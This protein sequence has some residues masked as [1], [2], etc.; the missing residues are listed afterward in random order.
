D[1]RDDADAPPRGLADGVEVRFSH[2]PL[3]ARVGVGGGVKALEIA[4]ADGAEWIAAERA[5]CD[6][7]LVSGGWSPTIHL[8]SHRGTRPVWNDQ[9]ACFLA[10]P[11]DDDTSLATVGAAAGIWRTD[12][13]IAS[14]AFAGAAAARALGKHVVADIDTDIDTAAR[15]PKPGGWRWPIRPLYE[16]RA[17]G[18]K[19]KSLVDPLNDVTAD[20]IRLAHREGFVAVEHLKRYTTLGMSTDGGKVGNVIGLALMAEALGT[21][22]RQVG[23]T[24][25]RPPYTPVAL[26]ALRGRNVGEHFRPLRRTPMHD[27]NLQRD[28]VM[29]MTGLWHRPWYFPRDDEDLAQAY[30]REAACVRE[31]VGLCDV[32]SLG[33]IAI[34]GPDASAFLD[35]IY[36]NPFAKLN[37]GK[38]RYGIMLRDDGIVMDD[39]T[40]WRLARCEYFM[41]TTTAHAAKVMAWLEELLHTRWPKLKVQVTSV[42]E[43]W[44]GCAVA[45]PKSRAVLAACAQSAEAV[46]NDALPFMGVIET[47]L[48]G[49][50]PCRIAR[51]SFSGE[52]AFEVYTP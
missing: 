52:M 4:V 33:K 47:T 2:A 45:G 15:A 20:D 32:T 10:S 23:A 26:G 41:T 6:L 39:G 25:F 42:S 18:R 24:V 31:H 28:A 44:A 51:I 27:W 29:T 34:Q 49:E 35:R 37:V 16:I 14:G 40:T 36:T 19:L 48:V 30:V 7:V 9:L 13:C 1:A 17:R 43:Q 11:N 22:V 38:A 8:T 46:S 12:A 50:I 3:R 21:T 5:R